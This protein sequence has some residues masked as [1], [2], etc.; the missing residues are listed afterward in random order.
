MS[1]P[2]SGLSERPGLSVQDMPGVEAIP[3]HP[4]LQVLESN[5]LHGNVD[6]RFSSLDS[7]LVS[8]ATLAGASVCERFVAIVPQMSDRYEDLDV[9]LTIGRKE[10]YKNWPAD[11]R[12]KEDVVYDPDR[13][14]RMIDLPTDGLITRRPGNGVMLN[15]ADCAATV[16]Y[17]PNERVLALGH[18]GREGAALDIGPKIVRYLQQTYRTKP[19]DLLVH[20]GASIAPESYLL[21]YVG[22]P[23]RQ[24]AWRPYIREVDGRFATDIV[25]YAAQRLLETGIQGQNIARSPIDVATH[26]DYFSFTEHLS[27]KTNIADGR[28]GFLVTLQPREPQSA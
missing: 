17:D 19:A 26:P 1:Q 25:G 12:P 20:F 7:F 6:P 8:R 23:L 5:R 10:G 13:P 3:V 2:I 4:D 9:G 27:D 11:L 15:T 18:I 28:N 22:E 14:P 24:E 16:I 21:T